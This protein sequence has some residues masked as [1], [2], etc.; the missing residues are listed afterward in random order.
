MSKRI[1]TVQT[2]PFSLSPSGS[3]LLV[4]GGRVL[5]SSTLTGSL[6]LRHTWKLLRSSFGLPHALLRLLSVLTS[7][8]RTDTQSI[9]IGWMTVTASILLFLL[10]CFRQL[11]Q[12]LPT[13]GN[14][15]ILLCRRPTRGL[16]Q[17]VVIGTLGSVTTVSAPTSDR[18]FAMSVETHTRQ[19]TERTASGN[20]K[21]GDAPLGQPNLQATI[22][23]MRE[24]RSLAGNIGVKRK[25][26][27]FPDS[28]LFHRRFV[29]SCHQSNNILS[30]TTAATECAEPLPSPPETLVTSP[31]I[32]STLY[33]LNQYIKVETPFN[34]DQL[35]N[36]LIDHQNQPFIKSIMRG[37]REGF[38]PFD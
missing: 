23:E 36:L 35:K 21:R 38:W 16:T 33:H 10:R 9:L 5:S 27:D 13:W 30:P 31:E 12:L 32:Q 22:S 37:L 18:M 25:G 2:N 6:S 7:K 26:P 1:I 29:W 4:P 24:T 19:R 8:L 14:I 15:K 28:P 17:S 20:S 34:V 11:L 3:E